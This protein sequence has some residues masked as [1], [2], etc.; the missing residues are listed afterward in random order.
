MLLLCNYGMS[1]LNMTAWLKLHGFATL[2]D[3]FFFFKKNVT[4]KTEIVY[5]G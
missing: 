1:Q 2:K 4:L 3:C 5:C